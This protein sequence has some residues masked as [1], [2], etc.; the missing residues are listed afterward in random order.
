MI[1]DLGDKLV[2]ADIFQKKFVCD[3]TACK[4]ACCVVGDAGAPLKLDEID[5][6]EEIVDEVKPYMTE[7][8]IAIVEKQGVFYMD[9]DKEPVTTL[10]ANGACAFATFDDKG[11]ALCTIEQAY[12]DGKID[13]KKPISCEL[14]PVRVKEYEKFTALNYEEIDICKPACECGD[15]LDISIFQFLKPALIRAFG[16]EFYEELKIVDQEIKKHQN[17]SDESN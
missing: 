6:L 9:L 11:T 14:F 7:E 16:E 12:R 4:G 2:S 17:T 15:K 8:G 5:I 1:I 3:L 13:W 10:V